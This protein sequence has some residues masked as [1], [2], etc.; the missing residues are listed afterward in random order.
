MEREGGQV[1][2]NDVMYTFD[3]SAGVTALVSSD[4]DRESGSIDVI[5]GREAAPSR[6]NNETYATADLTTKRESV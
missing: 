3:W 4:S 6:A 1:V 5:D 2:H